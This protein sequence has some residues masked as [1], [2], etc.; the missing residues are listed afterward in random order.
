MPSGLTYDMSVENEL[1]LPKTE[2]PAVGYIGTVESVEHGDTVKIK[3]ADGP[4]FEMPDQ[5]DWI[6][7]G[8]RIEV[9]YIDLTIKLLPGPALPPA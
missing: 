4:T 3:M 9:D 8:C 6:V 2:G 5:I 1:D 7:P